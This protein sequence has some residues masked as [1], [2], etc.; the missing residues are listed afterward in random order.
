MKYCA[1]SSA[2]NLN[3]CANLTAVPIITLAGLG[4]RLFWNNIT[5]PNKIC[6][7]NR[8]PSRV[9]SSD[10]TDWALRRHASA[11]STCTAGLSTAANLGVRKPRAST[12]CT[13]A[14]VPRSRRDRSVY[15][16]CSIFMKVG[17]WKSG[18]TRLN[19]EK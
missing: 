19:M 12:I 9:T 6:T 2:C 13:A 1:D 5:M 15:Q 14:Q 8:S 16:P 4:S 10:T 3:L 11:F 17:W 18:M 7:P